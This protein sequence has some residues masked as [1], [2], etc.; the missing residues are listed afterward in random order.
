MLTMF[1]HYIWIVMGNTF[2]LKNILCY[3]C[4]NSTDTRII[5]F[6]KKDGDY[7]PSEG[8][9]DIIIAV[10]VF[11]SVGLFYTMYYFCVCRCRPAKLANKD[12]QE[13]LIR[14]KAIR[15]RRIK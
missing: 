6:E 10:T 1:S 11:W 8:T 7:L 13:K 3:I 12:E 9:V 14:R 4:E 15:Q 5:Y 2:F